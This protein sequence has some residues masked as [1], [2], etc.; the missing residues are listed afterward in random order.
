[1]HFKNVYVIEGKKLWEVRGK[2]ILSN[3]IGICGVE[4]HLLAAR[5]YVQDTSR[6]KVLTANYEAMI[7]F[8]LSFSI[9][10]YHLMFQ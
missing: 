7:I 8:Y 3:G 5:E 1:M 6:L 2:E 9:S 4:G 10:S